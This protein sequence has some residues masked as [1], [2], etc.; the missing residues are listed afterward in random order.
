[1]SKESYYDRIVNDKTTYDKVIA[2]LQLM[3]KDG[4]NARLR[5]EAMKTRMAVQR[6]IEICEYIKKNS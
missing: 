4:A 2:D 3:E 6:V 5:T 1:M